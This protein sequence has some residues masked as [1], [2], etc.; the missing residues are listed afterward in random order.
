M[1][2]LWIL[3]LAVLLLSAGTGCDVITKNVKSI[4]KVSVY[5]DGGAPYG[6]LTVMLLDE[7]GMVKTSDQANERGVIVFEGVE[8]GTY[9]F[10]ARSLAGDLEIISPENVVVRPGKTVSVELKVKRA[11]PAE[12]SKPDW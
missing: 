11:L 1:R 10:A 6:Y 5:D 2:L 8:A 4:V 7:K 12:Q 3:A 9:T